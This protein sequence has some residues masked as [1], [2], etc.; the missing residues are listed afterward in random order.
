MQ[1][2]DR[3]FFLLGFLIFFQLSLAIAVNRWAAF[4]GLKPMPIA[5]P[6]L[7]C[8]RNYKAIAPSISF[9]DIPINFPACLM[10]IFSDK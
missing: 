8:R 1:Y 5:Q 4:Y 2:P 9:S 10:Y 7:L 6:A 3:F